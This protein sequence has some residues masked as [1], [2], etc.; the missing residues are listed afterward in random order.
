MYVYVYIY[1]YIYIYTHLLR[2]LCQHWRNTRR[3]LCPGGVRYDT[4]R[5]DIIIY[6]M[7]WLWH[8]VAGRGVA[9]HG[10]T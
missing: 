3:N 4:A 1:I 8:G 7:T 9:W 2:S 5:H 6:D 10:M